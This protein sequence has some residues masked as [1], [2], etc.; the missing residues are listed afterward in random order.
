MKRLDFG[1]VLKICVN[2]LLL[3]TEVKIPTQILRLPKG[4]QLWC[5]NITHAEV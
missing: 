3:T 2:I 4:Q 5:T 1:D